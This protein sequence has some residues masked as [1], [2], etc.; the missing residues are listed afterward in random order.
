[1]KMMLLTIGLVLSVPASVQLAGAQVEGPEA[2]AQ[3]AVLYVQ[4]SLLDGEKLRSDAEIVAAS[5]VLTEDYRMGLQHSQEMLESIRLVVDRIAP[6]NSAKICSMDRPGRN[7]CELRADA[8][9]HIG[10]PSVAGDSATILV[11]VWTTT[12]IGWVGLTGS[13][14]TLSK[15]NGRWMVVGR[16]QTVRS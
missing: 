16:V 5:E 14:I 7:K 1:M 6:L 12:E 4:E 13:K 8:V 11:N 2:I 9:L 15:R 3:Q 10:V